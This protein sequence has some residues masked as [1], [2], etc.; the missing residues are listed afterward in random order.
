MWSCAE[1]QLERLSK[2]VPIFILNPA[3]GLTLNDKIFWILFEPHK[4]GVSFSAKPLNSHFKLVTLTRSWAHTQERSPQGLMMPPGD[5]YQRII[6]SFGGWNPSPFNL[7]NRRLSPTI[8]GWLRICAG[9]WSL[10]T[11]TF[12]LLN[13]EWDYALTKVLESTLHHLKGAF[14]HHLQF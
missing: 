7:T 11:T 2:T 10:I 6:L 1:R 12:M 5:L 13:K 4:K 9:I 8:G 14:F 3:L